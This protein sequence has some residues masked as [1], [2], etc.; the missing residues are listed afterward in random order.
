M[1]LSYPATEVTSWGR[2]RGGQQRAEFAGVSGLMTVTRAL[3]SPGDDLTRA[4]AV[5]TEVIPSYEVLVTETPGLDQ[6]DRLA[7][8]KMVEAAWLDMSSLAELA[9]ADLQRAPKNTGRRRPRLD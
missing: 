3:R 1:V 8:K 9:E 5:R 6:I 4:V 2:S 7:M